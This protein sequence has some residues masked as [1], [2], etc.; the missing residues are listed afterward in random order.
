MQKRLFVVFVPF[1]CFISCISC[2]TSIYKNPFPKTED[3][4]A[5][6]AQELAQHTVRIDTT[7]V[8]L[9][10]NM[11]IGEWVSTGT[12]T[13]YDVQKSVD[14]YLSLILTAGHICV[15]MSD[16]V[17]VQSVGIQIHRT[18][19]SYEVMGIDGRKNVAM[20]IYADVTNDLCVLVVPDVVGTPAKIAKTAPPYGVVVEHVGAD[21]AVFDRLMAIYTVGRYSGVFQPDK[22]Q[23][24]W[25]TVNSILAMAGASGSAL[26]YNHEVYS[27][28]SFCHKGSPCYIVSGATTEAVNDAI[29]EANKQLVKFKKK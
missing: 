11:V 24:T 1:L 5:L 7:G 16:N 10:Q 9:A 19:T 21:N 6:G 8:T 17:V 23:G 26:Y 22:Q 18:I 14:G 20:P 13:V 15:D 27:V 12:G 4:D 3:R 29:T 25:F 28:L 2:A